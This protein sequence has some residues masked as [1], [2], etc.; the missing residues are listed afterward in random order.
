MKW[1]TALFILTLSMS[2][3]TGQQSASTPVRAVSS[4][5]LN[6]YTGK[7]YEIARY[8][9]RFQEQCAANTTATYT[10][11]E[12]WK[13]EVLNECLKKDGELNAA[14]GAAKVVDK[15]SNAKLKVRF[16]PGFLSVFG[17]VWGDY[18]V[19]DLGPNYEYSVVG[20]PDRKYL[21]ILSREPEINDP[22]YRDIIRRVEEQGFD[23]GK[24]IKT[25]QNRGS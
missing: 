19:I 5:D 12:A 3:A 6:R 14:K 23:S 20:D 24:L 1:I 25:A 22:V 17:F 11:K 18:W 21:W 9:N 10:I 4:V 8:P 7:W 13:I 2:M 15:S 16:A